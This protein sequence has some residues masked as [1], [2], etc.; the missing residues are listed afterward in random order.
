MGNSSVWQW[1]TPSETARAAA[2]L[3]RIH[4]EPR[5]ARLD[6]LQAS[7]DDVT[8][9]YEY[10]KEAPGPQPDPTH[11]SIHGQY[12]T[13]EHFHHALEPY[14]MRASWNG[15]QLTV[16][17]GSQWVG[18]EA[19]GLAEALQIPVENV[20]VVGQ[21]VGGAFGS[22]ALLLW[23]VVY[24]AAA[25][26]LLGRPVRFHVDRQLMATL[27][28]FRPR[29]FHDVTLSLDD[30]GLLAHHGHHVRTQTSRSDVVPLRGL[31]YASQMY[32]S[33][34]SDLRE[35]VVR[36]DVPTPGF[37]RAPGEYPVAFAYESA[38]DELATRTDTD[39]L[40][41]R[42]KNLAASDEA[43]GVGPVHLKACLIRASEIFGWS[44]RETE[45]GSMVD[46]ATRETLGWGLAG[47]HYPTY[48]GG[49]TRCHIE[50]E[51]RR[52]AQ[53]TLGAHDPGTGLASA[54]A[55]RV[56]EILDLPT[57]QVEVIL[58]DSQ[59]PHA[60]MAAGSASTRTAVAAAAEA[61]HKIRASRHHSPGLD[62]YRA[63]GEYRPAGMGPDQRARALRGQFEQ[64]GAGA[65]PGPDA[66]LR[67][68]VGA[69][70]AEV[71]VDAATGRARVRRMVGVFDVGSVLHR[72]TLTNQLEGGMIWGASH[73]LMEDAGMDPTTGRF[74]AT[75]LADYHFM[76]HADIPT[77]TV[78]V[79]DIPDPRSA[80]GAKGA[81]EIG[82]VGSSAAVTNAIHHATGIRVR[83]LPVDVQALF[84]SCAPQRIR[85]RRS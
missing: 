83:R 38:L 19:R 48:G 32:A 45:V 8:D 66:P 69:H 49:L 47:A 82:V 1:P 22:R 62:Q 40:E 64:V 85:N 68:S 23:H 67:L 63:A 28:S 57:A 14:S 34:S 27:G 6:L 16:D 44:E 30:E 50:Y 5:D 76:V 25:A 53:V 4:V 55:A 17:N 71:G 46:S 51:P 18:G 33:W 56:A 80:S 70:M 15:S 79:L 61:A 2:N 81:G 41:L 3:T 35:S 39:P 21:A 24:V 7:T 11:I 26:R 75:G 73:A 78:E 10:K 77:I 36:C 31:E 42:L 54:V 37:M 84:A 13:S 72:T 52:G 12:Q 59:L 43:T 20:R 65:D 9:V 74:L 60:P 58:G 29:T